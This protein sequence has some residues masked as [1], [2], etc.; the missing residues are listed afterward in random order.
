MVLLVTSPASFDGA[1]NGLV[2]DEVR[3]EGGQRRRLAE[4]VL[5]VLPHVRDSRLLVRY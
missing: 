4:R 2:L 5:V 1:G 3:V